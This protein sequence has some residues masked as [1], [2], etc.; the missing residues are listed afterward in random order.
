MRETIIVRVGLFASFIVGLA[1][2]A[3]SGTLAL[4]QEGERAPEA[5]PTNRELPIKHAPGTKLN[6]QQTRGAGIFIQHCAL[7]HLDKTFGTGGSK[8]CCVKS[9]GPRLQ[10]MFKDIDPE[11]EKAMRDFIMNGG[12]TYMPAF[13]YG[14]TP[15]EIDDIIAYLKTL[16]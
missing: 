14:L 7:C 12:P 15:K 10:G 4:A 8:F 3:G 13:K 2:F 9:L 1:L 5:A 16:E 11:Q 6:E